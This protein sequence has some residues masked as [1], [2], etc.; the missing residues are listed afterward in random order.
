MKNYILILFIL[1]ASDVFS[2]LINPSQG[3]GNI[4]QTT[5]LSPDE[6]EQNKVFA[7]IKAVEDKENFIEDITNGF[8]SLMQLPIGKKKTIGQLRYVVAIDSI[9]F[10]P[11]GSYFSA[12]AAI[13][14]PNTTKR[15]AFKASNIKFNPAGVLGGEQA[16]LY[17]VSKHIIKLSNKVTLVIPPN[18]QNYVQWDCDGYKSISISGKLIFDSLE[19]SP[20][21][22]VSDKVSADFTF[23]GES[24]NDMIM[25]VSITPFKL[26][27]LKGWSFQIINATFDWSEKSNAPNM[28]FP[29]GYTNPNLNATDSLGGSFSDGGSSNNSSPQLWTGFFLQSL[30]VKFPN[31]LNKGS[32]RSSAIVNNLLIDQ[33]GLT[34]QFIANNL[35]SV[36]EGNMGG[37][38]FSIDQAQVSFVANKI[39]SGGLQGKLLTPLNKLQSVDYT[40]LITYNVANKNVDYAFSVN[41][42]NDVS[43][44]V[45]QAQVN[46]FNSSY[47]SV[48]LVNGVFSPTLVLTGDVKFNA[49]KFNTNGAYLG[50]QSLTFVTSS[51]YITGGL[52][53]LSLPSSAAIKTKFFNVSL[54]SIGLGIINSKP[55]LSINCNIGITDGSAL[56]IAV[57]GGIVIHTQYVPP[58]NGKLFGTLEYEKITLTDIGINVESPI[59]IGGTISFKDDDPVY[60][61]GVFGQVN[62]RPPGLGGS[63]FSAKAGFGAVQNYKYFFVEVKVPGPIPIGTT[64]FVITQIIGGVYYKMQP[65]KVSMNDYIGLSNTYNL[66]SS[67]CSYTPN[68]NVPLGIKLGVGLGVTSGM[69]TADALLDISFNSNG[70]VNNV[71]LQGNAKTFAGPIL[72]YGNVVLNYN[73]P[74]SNFDGLFQIGANFQ[75]IITA[76]A[77]LK[78]HADPQNWHVCLGQ[79]STPAGISAMGYNLAG[80]YL[81]TGT[82]LE[83]PQNS[84]I[85]VSNRNNTNNQVIFGAS[86][87]PIS[88]GNTI[89]FDR[90]S[91][92]YNFYFAAGFDIL[93]AN[94]GNNVLCGDAYVTP[95]I[96]GRYV[97]GNAY[98]NLSAS[99]GLTFRIANDDYNYNIFTVNAEA[100]NTGLRFPN[101]IYMSANL[102]LQ[103]SF[104]NGFISINENINAQHGT[105]CQI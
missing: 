63:G 5:T 32:G 56:N 96:N 12:Y 105:Y 22:G 39:N 81:M 34:G 72:I 98:L 75:N 30:I 92:Y 69:V 84:N 27:K 49:P 103:A 33:M 45:F 20:D 16:K 3:G 89:G 82:A 9:D 57:N 64:P 7:T 104:F 28:V 61:D 24:L 91:L 100:R 88:G 36:G 65:N 44:D 42:T 51:P 25:Q 101:P 23:Q 53:S 58:T 48:A 1:L 99:A 83:L 29:N 14:V 70:G 21:D 17:L 80:G 18:N 19:F 67:K 62:F 46:I 31:E 55:Q 35:I 26:N 8:D 52:F 60:G 76:N 15:L 41:P 37:W 90:F 2:Q 54:N 87:P 97:V 59:L 74:T 93:I 85:P 4:S 102:S 94:Y 86:I 68:P 6:I 71:N 47:L 78:I 38:S 95:G 50:F 43:F 13:D 66:N 73:V 79:P 11:S 10:K 40:A 77:P